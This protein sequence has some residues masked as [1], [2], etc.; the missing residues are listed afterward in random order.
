M[1]LTTLNAW[2]YGPSGTGGAVIPAKSGQVFAESVGA[3][4]YAQQI[5]GFFL[6]TLDG[7]VTTGTVNW[8]DGTQTLPL[9]GPT[10]IQAFRQDPPAWTASSYYPLGAVVLGSGHV[11]QAT[12]AG[13]SGTSAP[14]FT[15]NGGTVGDVTG[16]ANGTLIWTDRGAIG[17]S[18]IT[19]ISFTAVTNTSATLTISA[20]GTNTQVVMFP[21]EILL[22]P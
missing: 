18:T 17:L 9:G 7:S 20:A 13:K 2:Y 14:S 15:T 8:I 21:F 1:A 19:P 5:F 4:T 3:G 22:Q 10:Y 12:T 16:N 11:Q 6:I